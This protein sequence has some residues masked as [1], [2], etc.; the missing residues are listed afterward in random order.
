MDDITDPNGLIIPWED[1]LWRGATVNYKRAFRL[2]AGNLKPTPEI[3][4]PDL[5][6][7]LFL[8]AADGPDVHQIW[9]FWLPA[10]HFSARWIPFLDRATP[11]NTFRFPG[12]YLVPITNCGPTEQMATK[13]SGASAM[14]F[15]PSNLGS[16]TP[17]NILYMLHQ[18]WSEQVFGCFL[19]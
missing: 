3:R 13:D 10:Q 6:H 5:C 15:W 11:E 8:Q 12:N 16:W 4:P 2:L 18:A 1:A 19:M 14:S 17:N 7:D 9:Q